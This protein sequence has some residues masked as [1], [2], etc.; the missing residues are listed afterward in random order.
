MFFDPDMR[1]SIILTVS[2]SLFCSLQMKGQSRSGAMSREL[3]ITSENDI[4]LY[5]DYYYTAGQK[6]EF[7]RLLSS[8]SR[9]FR[10]MSGAH[11]DSS[12]VII[13]YQIGAKIFT[14]HEIEYSDTKKMDRP[15]A[16]WSYAGINLTR[17]NT[18]SKGMVM[19]FELGVVGEASGMGQLQKWIHRQTNYLM[20][21][22][23]DSQ[24]KNE[25]VINLNLQMLRGIK[26]TQS[27]DLVSCTG[28]TAG[29]GL[30]RISQDF[31]FRFLKFNAISN[32]VFSNS[33]LSWESH[34]R[35]P[36]KEIFL[37][38]GVGVDYTFSNLFIEGS[39]FNTNKSPFTVSAEP[40]LLRTNGGIMY[41]LS[42]T[43]FAITVYHVSKE[44]SK[45]TS[46]TYG[47]LSLGYRF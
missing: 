11:S 10:L 27:F 19:G 33:S 1:I 37:F 42:R 43:S 9:L 30:N 28:A 2:I 21:S 12:R 8:D 39:I 3:K 17:F 47:G 16:G 14:P 38:A 44:V 4:Y 46:H 24:I 45:G 29:T 13:D 26:L 35:K 41:S 7:K 34:G 40:W 18:A 23:W 36:S 5:T 31:T 32:S 15:Y 6:I 25:I 22:G 20:P